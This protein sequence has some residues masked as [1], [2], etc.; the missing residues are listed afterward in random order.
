MLNSNNTGTHIRFGLQK[1]A[2]DEN[3][4]DWEYLNDQIRHSTRLDH[5]PQAAHW[6]RLTKTPNPTE[7]P[8]KQKGN[9]SI[10]KS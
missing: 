7:R 3:Q 8:E 10:R 9:I 1:V 6:A 4:S 5:S 2:M